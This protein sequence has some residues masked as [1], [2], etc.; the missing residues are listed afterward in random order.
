MKY[1]NSPI[2]Y[3]GGKRAMRDIILWSFPL[4]YGRYIEVFGGGA[5]VLFAKMKERF[6]V[7]NDFNGD[8]VNMFRCVKERPL[9]LIKALNFLPLHSR[10]EF[11]ILQNFLNGDEPEYPY[12]EMD[13]P[14]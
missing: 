8:L 9:A 3:I 11:S 10:Q 13:K 6:E 4:I 7:Y 5:S 2:P 12:N 1:Q 14:L